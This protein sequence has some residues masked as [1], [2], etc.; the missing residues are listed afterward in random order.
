MLSISQDA[1]DVG[2]EARVDLFL[3]HIGF[4]D[5]RRD[6]AFR[7][8]FRDFVAGWI[9]EVSTVF[10]SCNF[11]SEI[12]EIVDEDRSYAKMLFTWR[13]SVFLKFYCVH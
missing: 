10:S 5:E 8:V 9:W 12:N 13:W 3:E 6:V 11:V 4:D 1:V 7:A 2:F